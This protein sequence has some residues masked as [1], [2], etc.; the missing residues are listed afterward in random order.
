[1]PASGSEARALTKRPQVSEAL[2]QLRNGEIGIDEYLD[3]RA[4]A[5]VAHLT[6]FLTTTEL[7]TVRETIREQL[8]TDPL[9]LELVRRA[10]GHDV[11]GGDR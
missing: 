4:D 10:T 8:T 7:Q 1:M 5:A 6:N 3:V 9:L 2:R 11:S